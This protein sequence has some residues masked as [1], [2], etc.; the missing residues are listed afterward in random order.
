MF[1]SVIIG[2]AQWMHFAE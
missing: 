1:A 2:S